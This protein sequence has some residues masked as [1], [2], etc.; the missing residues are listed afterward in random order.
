VRDIKIV[1][2]F[3]LFP[4]KRVTDACSCKARAEFTGIKRLDGAAQKATDY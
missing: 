3:G 1:V 2:L 4:E